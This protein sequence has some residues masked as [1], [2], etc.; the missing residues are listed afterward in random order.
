MAIIAQCPSCRARIRAP[1]QAA[2][3]KAKCPKC[4]MSLT[5]SGTQPDEWYY[6]VMGKEIGPL[7]FW[8]LQRLTRVR[9]VGPETEV[10]LGT[11]GR[12][13]LAETVAGLFVGVRILPTALLPNDGDSTDEHFEDYF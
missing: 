13:V 5:V 6:R 12:W 9:K 3:R 10:R 4:H 1:E 2:G 11:N 7:P 8:V